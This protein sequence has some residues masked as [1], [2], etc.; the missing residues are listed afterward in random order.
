MMPDNISLKLFVAPLQGYTDCAWRH[1]HR[2]VYGNAANCYFSPFL[3]VEKG[4]PRRRDVRDITSP[5][6]VGVPLV[7]QIIFRDLS[8]FRI[9]VDA[10]VRE[11]H[12]KIDLNL[13]CPFPPQVKHGRGAALLRNHELLAA[14]ADVVNN[15][16][17]D[18]EF[19]VKMRLGVEHSNEWRSVIELINA[20]HLTHVTVHPRVAAQNYEGNLHMSEFAHLLSVCRHPMVFNGDIC[21]AAQIADLVALFPGLYGIMIGRGMLARPSIM[22]E[23]VE[24]TPWPDGRLSS[25]LLEFHNKLY[26]YYSEVMQGDTQILS[27]IKSFWDYHEPQI[28]HKAFKG[29]KKANTIAAYDKAVAALQLN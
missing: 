11:G 2:L 4:E 22:A 27:K 16:F 19:S 10:I 21:S 20:I 15:E 17:R 12:R 5:L 29:I 25:S 7:P 28:G 1:F 3:R 8:E 14:L 9:L 23:F 18:I 26:A 13:G 6:N 24:G